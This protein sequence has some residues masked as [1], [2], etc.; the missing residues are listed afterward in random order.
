M[1]K[2]LELAKLIFIS[3]EFL[4]LVILIAVLHYYPNI[5]EYVGNHFKTNNDIWKFLPTIPLLICGF[6]IKY[7]WKIL[8][9]IDSGSNR[10]LHEWPNYWKLKYRVILSIFICITCTALSVIMWMFSSSLSAGTIGATF[11]GSCLIALIVAFN[12]LLAAFKVREL[13][14]P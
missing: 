9:P 2:L 14:E 12:Q 4:F 3:F 5:F 10:I 13:M 8:M 7:A 1:I 11:F 6:S